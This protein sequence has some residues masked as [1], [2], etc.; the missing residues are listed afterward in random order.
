MVFRRVQLRRLRARLLAD[1]QLLDLAFPSRMA[2]LRWYLAVALLVSLFVLSVVSDAWQLGLG[3]LAAG[4]LLLAIAEL[5]ASYELLA[6]TNLRLLHLSGLLGVHLVDVHVASITDSQEQ[7]SFLGMLLG[8][9]TL[10]INTAG[11]D[12][13][14]VVMPGLR[15]PEKRKQLIDS[16]V[17]MPRNAHARAGR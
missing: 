17:H 7:R 5:R 14:E 12:Q 10:I 11:S 6:V 8:Y 4:F 15:H 2:L 16:L 13:P 1:E 3:P 9:G